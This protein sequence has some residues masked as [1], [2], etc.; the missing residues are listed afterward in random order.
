MKVTLPSRAHQIFCQGLG[1]QYIPGVFL[2]IP[3]LNFCPHL[4]S[5]FPPP[6]PC[7]RGNDQQPSSPSGGR[8]GLHFDPT[9]CIPRLAQHC[10]HP[11]W[12]S[13]SHRCAG[14]RTLP[15]EVLLGGGTQLFQVVALSAR[16]L[17]SSPET[18]KIHE[19]SG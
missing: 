10:Q 2:W 7:L 14:L 13:G 8:Q 11:D 16:A 9:Q 15:G 3:L 18:F 6:R 17:G 12:P 5:I 1:A 4:S 19:S